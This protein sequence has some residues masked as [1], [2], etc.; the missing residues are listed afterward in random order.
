[1]YRW[2]ENAARCYVYLKDTLKP[3]S[4]PPSLGEKEDWF[5]RG[6][7]LQELIAPKTVVFFDRNWRFLGDKYSLKRHISD[8]TGISQSVLVGIRKPQECSIEERMSWACD[9]ETTKDEDRVYSLL[10][11]FDVNMPML[12]GEGETKAFLR[13]QEEIAKTLSDDSNIVVCDGLYEPHGLLPTSPEAFC[14]YNGMKESMRQRSPSVY[15][16]EFYPGTP[17]NAPGPLDVH[18]YMPPVPSLVGASLEPPNRREGVIRP[19]ECGICPSVYGISPPSR[20][21]IGPSKPELNRSFSP[22]LQS[23]NRS[24]VGSKPLDYGKIGPA[25]LGVG[26]SVSPTRHLPSSNRCEGFTYRQPTG[27]AP[28]NESVW[29]SPSGSPMGFSPWGYSF[30]S[31]PHGMIAGQNPQQSIW[32]SNGD[33]VD[34]YL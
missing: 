16:Q 3:T 34:I 1:M 4:G 28:G 23:P 24:E 25:E 11:L 22:T 12:Y 26:R 15:G 32:M 13:L 5:K 7:T 2:Y 19:P 20:G 33:R 30:E 17:T 31:S 18:I 14:G 21:I 29:Q 8:L 27:G 9:R 6:W 10:G